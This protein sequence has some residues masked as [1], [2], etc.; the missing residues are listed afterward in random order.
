M[1]PIANGWGCS[2]RESAGDRPGNRHPGHPIP[3]N[4]AR[5]ETQENTP[6]YRSRMEVPRSWRIVPSQACHDSG[7]PAAG[8]G[9][10][11]SNRA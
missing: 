1:P 8:A 4:A 10:V 2:S 5:R 11:A 7:D 9:P 6:L 3:D